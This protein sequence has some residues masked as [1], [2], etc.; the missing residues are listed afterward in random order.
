M[1]CLSA[2]HMSYDRGPSPLA[3][4]ESACRSWRRR[5]RISARAFPN[6][7]RH[8][9]TPPRSHSIPSALELVLLLTCRSKRRPGDDSVRCGK[10]RIR[11]C[12]V[13]ELER[14]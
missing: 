4:P 10:G 3:D 5:R 14:R 8:L 2:G 11:R 12:R 9:Q 1:P 13:Q 6:G 7:S